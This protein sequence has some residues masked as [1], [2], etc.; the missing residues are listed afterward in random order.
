LAIENEASNIENDDQTQTFLE[1]I[2]HHE[3]DINYEYTVDEML[4]MAQENLFPKKP[5]IFEKK[6][7]SYSPILWF[8]DCD[9]VFRAK[10]KTLI[11]RC[12]ERGHFLN[13]NG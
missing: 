10:P 3:K 13:S 5:F 4:K 2:M 1:I 7:K 11:L 9:R 8:F 12:K 6:T